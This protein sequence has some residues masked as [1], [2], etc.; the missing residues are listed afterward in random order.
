VKGD[1]GATGPT[2]PI[3]PSGAQGPQGLAGATGAV[4]PQGVIGP[5]GPTGDKGDPGAPG[6][7]F[8]GAWSDTQIYH[9]DDVVTFSGSSWAAATDPAVGAAP[10]TA[11]DWTLVA[12]KG[13]AGV[14]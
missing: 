6:L 2:G 11:T 9:L 5:V 3:G 7:V 10:G 12:S 8:R 1:P 13:D 4:G 14:A